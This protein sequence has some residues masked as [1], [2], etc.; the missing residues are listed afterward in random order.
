[1]SV[2]AAFPVCA[3]LLVVWS[4]V[5]SPHH[6]FAAI[7]DES[8]SVTL[9]GVVRE[10]RFVHPHP[11]LVVGVKADDGKEQSWR[12]EMDNRYELEDIGI[13]VQTFRPGDRV[14][15]TGSPGR[16]QANTLY[17]WK[18]ERP[19]DGLFYQQVG[20]TPSIRIPQQR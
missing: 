12:A 13:T 16:W 15:L 19:S 1:M 10:F 9:Q 3:A 14:V 8:R 5:A 2:R 18:L 11:I 17:L 4:E 20:G 7:Y 6:S